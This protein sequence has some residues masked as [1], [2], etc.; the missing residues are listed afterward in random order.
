MILLRVSA[1]RRGGPGRFIG[2]RGATLGRDA[3][4]NGPVCATGARKWRSPG[5]ASPGSNLLRYYFNELYLYVIVTVD[6]PPLE[7]VAFN[8]VGRT[9]S[10]FGSSRPV[11][12]R[13][14]KV[15]L[16]SASTGTVAIEWP[17]AVPFT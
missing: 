16:P 3:I 8:V 1:S 7:E 4:N 12:P 5:L 10:V 2:D 15:Q 17:A 14:S 6:E 9:A 11:T 13:M